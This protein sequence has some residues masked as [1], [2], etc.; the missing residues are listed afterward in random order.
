MKQLLHALPYTIGFLFPMIAFATFLGW[1]EFSWVLPIVAFVI[2]PIL[3]QVLPY[4]EDNL[5]KE[6]VEDLKESPHSLLV[7]AMLSSM[8][9]DC[10]LKYP[11]LLLLISTGTG[12]V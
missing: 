7:M 5:S 9:V 8:D 4:S 11:P 12:L 2:I 10:V 3:D 1:I 6:E